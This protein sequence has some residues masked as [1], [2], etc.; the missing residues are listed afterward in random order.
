MITEH[1]KPNTIQTPP[2]WYVFFILFFCVF[3][4]LSLFLSLL[5]LHHR[6]HTTP[7]SLIANNHNSLCNSFRSLQPLSLYRQPS[8]PFIAPPPS[9]SLSFDP[10]GFPHHHHLR[11]LLRPYH[12]RPPPY[13]CEHNTTTIPLLLRSTQ[14]SQITTHHLNLN[15]RFV[16][17]F[18]PASPS[19]DSN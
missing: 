15:R 4:L 5:S 7:C 11:F 3:F 17:P 1:K 6:H 19:S 14:I 10:L 18:W 2:Y 12:H 13:L 9:L 8:S 16:P